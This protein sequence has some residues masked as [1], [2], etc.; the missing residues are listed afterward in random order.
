[1]SEHAPSTVQTRAAQ[2]ELKQLG[3]RP[4]PAPDDLTAPYW[5]AAAKQRL[6]AERCTACGQFRHPPAAACARCGAVDSEW[7]ELSGRGTVFS[8][9]VDH[10]N[11]VPGFDGAYVVALVTPDEVEDNS[12]RFATNLPGCALAD[13]RIGMPVRVVFDELRPGVWLPQFTPVERA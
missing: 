10:R 1:M 12:V 13:V 7:V 11:M 5:A 3:I 2:E 6:V 8:F 9:I 4:W